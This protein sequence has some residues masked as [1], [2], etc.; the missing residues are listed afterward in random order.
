MNKE[1]SKPNKR[2]R[3]R[4]KPVKRLASAKDKRTPPARNNFCIAGIGASAGG[5]EALEQF[6]QNMP[7]EPGIAFVVVQHLDPV[8]SSMLTSL[9]MRYTDMEVLQIEDGT[10]VA[11]NRVYVI[12]PNKDLALFHGTLCLIDTDSPHGFRLP[13]DYF[14][15][16]LAEDQQDKAIGIVLS[17]TGTDGSLG[18]KAIKEAGGMT[19]AQE[20]DS[21]KFNNMPRSAIATGCIDYILPATKMPAEIM[22]YIKHPYISRPA[23]SGGGEEEQEQAYL[24]KIFILLRT[25]TGSD[26]T[27]YK[28]NTINRRIER[29]MAVHQLKKPEDYLRYLQQNKTEID[30]LFKELLIGVT[31]FFR[32]P[33]S[34]VLLKEKV[35]PY[36]LRH[37]SKEMPV[38]T[39]VTGCST[40]EEAYSVAMILLEVM[41]DL[42][43]NLKI[44]I[45]ATDID[46]DA[47]AFARHGAYPESIVAD[48][49][50]ERLRR[51][52]TKDGHSYLIKKQIREMIIFAKQDVL[53]DPPFSKL[54]LILCRNL[55]IYFGLPLQKK[56]FPL[57]HYTL[58]PN[59]FLMLGP[60]ETIGEFA[61]L[62]SL[63]D[64][65][66]KIFQRKSVL[67]RP[68]VE[69]PPP[70]S[71][72]ERQKKEQQHP[73][74][75]NRAN[76]VQLSEKMLL[77]GYT[78]PSVIINEK[79]DIVHFHGQIDQFLELP[80]GEG[81]LSI[82]KMARED[83]RGELRSAI[84]KAFRKHTT[85]VRRD[86][87]FS[88][89]GQQFRVDLIVKPFQQEAMQGLMLVI[90][91]EADNP[92]AKSQP[93]KKTKA[94]AAADQRIVDLEFELD[95]TKESLQGAI[96]ELETSNEE[97]KSAN[98]ELQSTNEELETSREE[99]QSI[100]EELVT[101]NAELQ[102]KLDELSQVNN[103]MV[104][105]LNSTNIGTVFLDHQ[106]RVKRFTP[107]VAKAIN[108]IA[109]DIGRPINHITSN[110]VYE[111]LVE[112][113]GEVLKTLVFKE[114]E[115][116]TRGGDWFQVRL[117]PYRT[118]DNI[119]DG[120]V[121]TFI[122]ISSRK[123]EQL[124]KEVALAY[125]HNI[126]AMIEEPVLVLSKNLNIIAANEAFYRTFRLKPRDT[127]ERSIYAL[128]SEWDIPALK[129]LLQEDKL[130]TSYVE[131][132]K[133]EQYFSMISRRVSINA[134]RLK[135][136][137]EILAGE[138]ELILLA[139]NP[140]GS[141]NRDIGGLVESDG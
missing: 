48:V 72:A 138:N 51:F 73:K 117:A 54:D 50:S 79:Y 105:L 131:N 45:F 9:I 109:S 92:L 55:L 15:R 74:P 101:V 94:L 35:I 56:I 17:G 37:K 14:F 69:F 120:V 71:K 125:A 34:F 16:S 32:D 38:R 36:I 24:D 33:D 119:I 12:P 10:R 19:M 87:A 86:V 139:M 93:A 49:T 31:N 90:F 115:L 113:I 96:E 22:R 107:H 141:A 110:L 123:K 136:A 3:T 59:G 106:L 98:E 21:A 23:E 78:P 2:K 91:E 58:N 126:L 60:S 134:R 5:L 81:R 95:S 124:G 25:H 39:W 44:Q 52:F 29:R 114:R 132:F 118:I 42:S 83:I 63:V 20:G 70:L 84:H 127:L 43:T 103:D 8:H 11:Q 65:K 41:E 112:D 135:L 26:F 6:F 111:N 61:D 137:A 57:F 77:E 75:V 13:I 88:R 89:L 27:Y 46:E 97:L 99:L 40:G 82:L 129:Q 47:L 116:Q 102:T 18:V 133:I 66:W 67:S 62:F 140:L 28:R 64:K 76:A 80:K 130:G 100:N 53:Q 104:N 128:G 85:V 68:V 108:L 121:I 1:I 30:A 122:D 7:D 4:A